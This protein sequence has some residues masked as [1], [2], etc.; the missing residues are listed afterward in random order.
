MRRPYV[1][2]TLLLC[3]VTGWPAI[4]SGQG[5]PSLSGDLLKPGRPGERIRVIVQAPEGTEAS[6]LRGHLRGLVRRELKGAVALELSRAEL[7][8][9]SRDSA[10]AHISADMPVAPDMAITN[11]VTGA[12]AVWQGTSSLLGSTPRRRAGG[13]GGAV[14][15]SGSAPHNAIADRGVARVNL[16]SWEP[17][18]T[19]DPYGHGTHV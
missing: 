6:G 18:T 16:G 11:K 17:P 14:V 15:D 3:A 12:S 7:D 5:R 8:S 2:L 13:S 4:P 19:G 1:F 9:L 10:F